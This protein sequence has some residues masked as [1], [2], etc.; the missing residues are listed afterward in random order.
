MAKRKSTSKKKNAA[1][2]APKTSV[3]AEIALE[4]VVDYMKRGG[5]VDAKNLLEKT[6]R[7]KRTL[8][9]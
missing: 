7:I 4:A 1:R 5:N 2:P 8:E 9:G 6:D 3:A